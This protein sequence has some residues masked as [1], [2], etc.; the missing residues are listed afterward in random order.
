[1]STTRTDTGSRDN[2]H[3][4]MMN[5][6]SMQNLHSR[7][8]RRREIMQ[9]RMGVNI[10]HR[11]KIT[12]NRK[13]ITGK[14]QTTRSEMT[15]IN[16]MGNRTD[17]DTLTKNTRSDHPEI[18]V[19]PALEATAATPEEEGTPNITPNPSARQPPRMALLR[20]SAPVQI[21]RSVERTDMPHCKTVIK[22]GVYVVA[23][24]IGRNHFAL[25]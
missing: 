15:N 20:D 4:R 10:R 11:T 14:K 24:E 22:A 3:N 2:F 18:Q 19:S 9:N 16:N 5:M 7:S 8:I 23:I 21:L 1:M 17:S 6:R 12:H 25:L 13:E